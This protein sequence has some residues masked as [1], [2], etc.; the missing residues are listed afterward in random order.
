MKDN[1]CDKNRGEN[2]FAEDENFIRK[3]R[4]D[5]FGDMRVK[6]RTRTKKTILPVKYEHLSDSRAG[7]GSLLYLIFTVLF[8]TASFTALFCDVASS[9]GNSP[10]EAMGGFAG[11]MIFGKQSQAGEDTSV[12]DAGQVGADVTD[13]A[14]ETGNVEPLSLIHI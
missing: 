1:G 14:E 5:V 8:L 11:N 12:T 13:R 7:T 2:G 6:K 4:V 9:L 10:R 3:E